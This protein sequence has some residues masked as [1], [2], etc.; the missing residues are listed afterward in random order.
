MDYARLPEIVY[1]SNKCLLHIKDKKPKN[2]LYKI[3]SA[4]IHQH[5]VGVQK[6]IFVSFVFM[7]SLLYIHFGQFF[8]LFLRSFFAFLRKDMSFGITEVLKTDLFVTYYPGIR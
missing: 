4:V 8:L 1:L 6:Q 2:K 5:K 3:D 7:Y